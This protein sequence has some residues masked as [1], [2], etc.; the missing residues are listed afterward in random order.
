MQRT[1]LEQIASSVYPIKRFHFARAA[2]G[3]HKWRFLA[4]RIIPI[5]PAGFV[6]AV[7]NLHEMMEIAAGAL[8][9]P[10]SMQT[11]RGYPFSLHAR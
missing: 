6:S 8:G 11:L 4:E 5:A 9:A 2:T 3:E 7:K 10:R 1:E